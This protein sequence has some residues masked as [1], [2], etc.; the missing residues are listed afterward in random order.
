MVKAKRVAI[1]LRVS[2]G[3]QTVENQLQALERVAV[4]RGWQVVETYTDRGI[5]GSKGRDKRPALDKMLKDAQRGRFDLIAAWSLDRLGRSVVH[6][7]NMLAELTDQ[8][9][10]VYLDQQNIDSSTA[11][12]KAMLGMC[13]VFAEFE[14]STIVERVK[15]GM[16]RAAKA[17]THCG[18]PTLPDA[19]RQAIIKA[20]VPGAKYRAIGK[21]LDVSDATV[22]RVARTLAA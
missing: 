7:V 8:G 15:A 10:G 4:H 3:D 19:T 9:V 21:Q 2:T 11:A 16:K 1:Y 14:R 18:R 17:G 20:L 12:G 6:L 13:A 5:S 22:R